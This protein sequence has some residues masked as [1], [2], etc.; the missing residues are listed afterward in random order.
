MNNTTRVLMLSLMSVAV[1]AGCKKDVKPTPSEGGFAWVEVGERACP[2]DDAGGS[3]G[4]QDFLDRLRFPEGARHLALEVFARSFF[5]HPTEFG[6]G[7]LVGM[8]D[9]RINAGRA[10]N[11]VE[12]GC[13]YA[14]LLFSPIGYGFVGKQGQSLVVNGIKYFAVQRL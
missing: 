13:I 14:R 10:V 9:Q 3:G 2:P 12:L 4:Y 7:E 11:L 8:F 6:A 1:L 5:A